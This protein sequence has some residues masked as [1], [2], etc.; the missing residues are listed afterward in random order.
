MTVTISG[1][2]LVVAMSLSACGTK[3]AE[4]GTSTTTTTLAVALG[5]S[6]ASSST[7]TAAETPLRGQLLAQGQTYLAAEK[8]GSVGVRFAGQ[9]SPAYF[10]EGPELIGMTGAGDGSEDLMSIWSMRSLGIAK[11][12]FLNPEQV[13]SPAD[14]AR[15]MSPAPPDMLAWLSASPF[16]SV[17]DPR[18]PTTVGGYPGEEVTFSILP[19]PPEAKPNSSCPAGCAVL[20]VG[21]GALY[22]LEYRV[23]RWHVAIIDVGGER[24]LIQSHET[25][26]SDGLRD[27]LQFVVSPSSS[28]S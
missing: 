22:G 12:P 16:V 3:S 25:P 1:A 2:V 9:S 23:E 26:T 5:A 8:F 4:R 27:S 11:D 18:H 13:A 17:V 6:S 14:L 28:S 19:L 24:L 21:N 7:S 10:D 20:W 15:E